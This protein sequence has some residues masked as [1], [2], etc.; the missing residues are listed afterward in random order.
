LFVILLRILAA[1]FNSIP[2]AEDQ[3]NILDIFL[4]IYEKIPDPELKIE[5]INVLKCM[6][7][8]ATAFTGGI[9]PERYRSIGVIDYPVK[10]TF[11]LLFEDVTKFNEHF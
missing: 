8:G 10:K 4:S 2:H 5:V 3:A 9:V 7:I 6:F 1:K 11:H